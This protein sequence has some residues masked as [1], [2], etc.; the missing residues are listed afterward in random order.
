M[1]ASTLFAVVTFYPMVFAAPTVP[2]EVAPASPPAL[3]KDVPADVKPVVKTPPQLV[4]ESLTPPAGAVLVGRPVGLAEALASTPDRATQFE[5]IRAYW[6]L[7]EAV[8]EYYYAAAAH[9]QLQPLTP[10]TGDA[11]VLATAQA[12]AAA[13]VGEAELT[14]TVAQHGLMARAAM[15]A[16][17]ALPLPIDR[18][19]AGPYRTNFQQLQAVRTLSP[20]A[21]LVDQAL[22]VA[23]RALDLRAIAVSRAEQSVDE[24]LAAYGGG[25]L[26]CAALLGRMAELRRQRALFLALIEQYNNDIADYALEVAGPT[27]TGPALVGM[28]IDT[29]AGAVKPTLFEA[30]PPAQTA[31][32]VTPQPVESLPNL[33]PPPAQPSVPG[34][35]V[36]VIR[37]DQLPTGAAPS[38]NTFR[39][40]R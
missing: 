37:L 11:L 9:A 16:G 21:A 33:V 4:A 1:A 8:A 13:A 24:A 25:R 32:P 23:R 26:D 34:K 2:V 40:S 19:H 20:R 5:A 22:P 18:P 3:V 29:A 7:A 10:R 36:P 31:A 12:S 17:S 30:A 15:P 14:V 35:R 6:G 27:I 39:N 28:L 38:G